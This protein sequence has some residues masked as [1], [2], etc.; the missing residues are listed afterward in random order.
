MSSWK[1]STKTNNADMTKGLH[2][3]PGKGSF[4]F[5][6]AELTLPSSRVCVNA[7]DTLPSDQIAQIYS[8]SSP[9]EVRDIP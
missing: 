5:C 4:A 9:K 7:M 3:K 2:E 8:E 1:L 6:D